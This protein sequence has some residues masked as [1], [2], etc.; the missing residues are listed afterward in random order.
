MVGHCGCPLIQTEAGRRQD[1]QPFEHESVTMGSRS[2]RAQVTIRD[3][4]HRIL[5]PL[6]IN[7]CLT[8]ALRWR[9]CT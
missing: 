2:T 1:L 9:A 5:L 7:T 6:F 8:R 4:F 3:T